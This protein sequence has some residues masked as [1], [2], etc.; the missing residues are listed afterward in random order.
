MARTRIEKSSEEVPG[1]PLGTA[2]R[3]WIHKNI[4]G[5]PETP[6]CAAAFIFLPNP[7]RFCSIGAVTGRAT[8]LRGKWKRKSG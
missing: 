3:T 7:L 1:Q 2:T 8:P 4:S 6:P 5:A